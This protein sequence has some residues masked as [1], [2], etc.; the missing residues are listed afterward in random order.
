MRGTVYTTTLLYSWFVSWWW[1]LLSLSIYDSFVLHCEL[2]HMTLGLNLEFSFWEGFL[3]RG[4]RLVHIYRHDRLTGVTN[5]SRRLAVRQIFNCYFHDE[6]LGGFISF[7]E[8]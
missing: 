3:G 4:Q 5:E 7:G 6:G 1:K 8:F 2:S